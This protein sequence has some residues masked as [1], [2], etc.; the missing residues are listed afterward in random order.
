MPR[1]WYRAAAGR[2]RTPL[3]LL[4][5][6][7]RDHVY[8]V[9]EAGVAAAGRPWPLPRSGPDVL[10]WACQLAGRGRGLRRALELDPDL[11]SAHTTW[12]ASTPG[13]FDAGP[14]S[15]CSAPP[16]S[17]SGYY[18]ARAGVLAGVR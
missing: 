13:S 14:A 7:L 1:R 10:G 9:E 4:L 17:T 8:R 2:A 15:T 11:A 5:A 16:I 3:Q 12:A 18:R 6:L